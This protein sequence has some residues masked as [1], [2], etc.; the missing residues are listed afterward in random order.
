ME[1]RESRVWASERERER[2]RERVDVKTKWG[3][4]S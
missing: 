2:E 4:D 1:K 3:D